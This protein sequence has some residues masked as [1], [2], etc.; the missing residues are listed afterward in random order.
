MRV[1]AY[2][3]L[4]AVLAASLLAA[5]L[6]ASSAQALIMKSQTYRLNGAD[7]KERLTVRCPGNK[8]LPYSGGMLTDPLGWEMPLAVA[9]KLELYSTVAEGF[10]PKAQCRADSISVSTR[11]R[12]SNAERF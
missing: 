12:F 10:R 8:Q 2:S 5:A 3:L 1:R 7:T 4:P 6:L 9:G 11:I